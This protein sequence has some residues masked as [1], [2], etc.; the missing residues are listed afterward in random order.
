MSEEDGDLYDDGLPEGESPEE[1]GLVLKFII[2]AVLLILL[3]AVA[4]ILL[5][6]S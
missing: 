3:Y 6:A 1:D 5:A 4:T 2:A